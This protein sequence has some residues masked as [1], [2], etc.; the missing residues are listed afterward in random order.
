ML[1]RR[2]LVILLLA[3]AVLAGSLVYRRRAM[4]QR[5]RVDLY[6]QDGSM[7]SM[8]GSSPDAAELLWLARELLAQP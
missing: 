3:T 6:A 1:P 4:R 7:V 5:E 8:P 2:L